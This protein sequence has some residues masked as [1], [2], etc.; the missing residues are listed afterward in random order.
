MYNLTPP[1]KGGCLFSLNYF[2]VK[3]L[4]IIPISAR[5]I[6]RAER[7][8]DLIKFIVYIMGEIS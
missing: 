8:G 2:L 5:G 1:P 4:E 3:I 6:C 7:W